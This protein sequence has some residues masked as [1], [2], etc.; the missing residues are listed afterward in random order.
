MS[1]QLISRN[2]DL[3]KLRDN[4]YEVEAHGDLRLIIRN[5]PYLDSGRKVQRGILVSNLEFDGT[6]L[7]PPSDHTVRFAGDMPHKADG[8]SFESKFVADKPVETVAPGVT[9]QFRFSRMPKPDDRYRDYFHK[10]TTYIHYLE[11]EAQLVDPGATAQTYS[12]V[13]D[14]DADSVFHYYDT[15]SSRNGTLGLTEK[16]AKGPIAIVGLGGAGSYVLDFVAKTPANEIHLFDGDRFGNHN[17][18]RAP[19]APSL[20]ELQ[21]NPLKVDYFA[22]VYSRMRR[23]IMPHPQFITAN[24]VCELAGFSFVFICVDKGSARGIIIPELIRLGVPFSDVGMEVSVVDERLRGQLRVTTGSTEWNAHVKERVG[25][26]DAVGDGEYASAIQIA[27][28]NA[29]N[30]A[31]AVLKWKKTLGFFEDSE[32]EHHTTYTLHANMLQNLD[33]PA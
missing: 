2:P 8:S 14:D 1:Q 6:T 22:G 7:K 19:G 16:L 32:H 27:E 31:L 10:M 23:R 21:L 20:A 5:V 3:K 26:G 18:F 17:A 9:V 4:G 29:L 25:F 33:K 15:N 12:P 11:R 24:N 30:A 13:Q 28:L